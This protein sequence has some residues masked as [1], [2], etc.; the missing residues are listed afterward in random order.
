MQKKIKIF[1][2]KY[3]MIE[4]GDHIVAGISGG[5]DSVCLLLILKELRE[6]MDFELTAVHVEH[7]IRGEESL[8]DAAFAEKFCQEQQIP[9]LTFSVDAPKKAKEDRQTLEEAARELRYDCFYQACQSCGGNKIA[10]AHHGDDCAE[11]MLFHLSRGTGIRGLCGIAPMRDA[12]SD[13]AEPVSGKKTYPVIR[14]MLGVARSEIEQFLEEQGQTYCTDST[15]M[16]VTLARNRIRSKILPELSAIN[17]Q[18]VQHMVRTAGYLEEV[19]DFLDEAAWE[20]GKEGVICSYERDRIREIRISAEKFAVL[21]PVLQKNLLHRL[22]G[23]IAGSRKDITALHIDG[24]CGLF[25][26]GAVSYTHLW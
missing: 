1:L 18:T 3:H 15:N 11:T 22:L 9:F 20:A 23:E 5:A 25:G 26:S 17:P 7:G 24:V 10:V 2:E 8:R 6:T 4:Q 12:A 16:D 21:H 14:P 19:C 13:Q